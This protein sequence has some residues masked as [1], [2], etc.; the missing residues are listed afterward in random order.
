[1]RF[2][3]SAPETSCTVCHC[4]RVRGRYATA[5]IEERHLQ[6]P[7]SPASPCS[8]LCLVQF[9]CG[10]SIEGFWW[11]LSQSDPARDVKPATLTSSAQQPWHPSNL[12]KMVPREN[13]RQ[14]CLR[15]EFGSM[16]AGISST[17]VSSSDFHLLDSITNEVAGH[18]G[19]MLQARQLGNELVVGIHS[20]ESILENKGPT[21]MTLEER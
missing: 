19:A 4:T 14:K 10:R 12:K 3:H 11:K 16:D 21:V 13:Q 2:Q 15:E 17:M 9:N 5:R 7:D 20:D 8:T 6:W 18:A 1:M